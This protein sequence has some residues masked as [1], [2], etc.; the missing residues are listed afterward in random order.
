MKPQADGHTAIITGSGIVSSVNI[1]S[2][3]LTRPLQKYGSIKEESIQFSDHSYYEAF[4]NIRMYH[5]CRETRVKYD[6]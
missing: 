5:G 2:N 6:R 1:H 4:M 3:I